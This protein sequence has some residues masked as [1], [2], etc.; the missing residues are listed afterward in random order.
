MRKNKEISKAIKIHKRTKNID[1]EEAFKSIYELYRKEPENFLNKK[2]N[3]IFS[4]KCKSD[5][6]SAMKSEYRYRI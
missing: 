4:G 2:C 1:P 6:F 3:D 5:I